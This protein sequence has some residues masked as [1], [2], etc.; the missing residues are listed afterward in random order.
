[1]ANKIYKITFMS[2]LRIS[3]SREDGY[4][5]ASSIEDATARATTWLETRKDVRG[6][7]DMV[8]IRSIEFLGYALEI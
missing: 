3:L 5:F 6:D 4:V 7:Q 1:M 8:S 2:E